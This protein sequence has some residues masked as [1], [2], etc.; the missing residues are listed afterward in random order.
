MEGMGN[1]GTAGKT[2]V[3]FATRI[4][5]RTPPVTFR[6]ASYEGNVCVRLMTTG[7]VDIIEFTSVAMEWRS[8]DNESQPCLRQRY[9]WNRRVFLHEQRHIND[10]LMVTH[11]FEQQLN[12]PIEACASDQR[13][14]E[15][16][17]KERIQRLSM[18]IS[19]AAQTE[20]D[21]L[22]SDFHASRAG[23]PISP[24]DCSICSTY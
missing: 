3:Q 5:A 6:Q 11:Q 24:L 7:S 4:D 15:A 2:R 17:L 19:D 9:D 10:A 12:Q 22:T 18:Q 8:R 13:S 23:G 14:A 16:L 21:R 20:F 1:P